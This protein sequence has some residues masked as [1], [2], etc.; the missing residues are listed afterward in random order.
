MFLL[1]LLAGSAV[2]DG[3]VLRDGRFPGK[4]TA[5]DLTPDQAARLD[6]IR[7]CH[8]DN[9]RTPYVF[10]LT[11]DQSR[12][13]KKQT[14]VWAERFAVLDSTHGASGVGHF[15]AGCER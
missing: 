10:H 15:F 6:Y 1:S 3:W 9:T 4:S 7:K 11:A 13:L 2:A 5:I 14:G 8:R 12:L